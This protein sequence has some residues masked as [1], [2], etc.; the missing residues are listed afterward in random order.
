MS[1]MLRNVPSV[2]ELLESPPLKSLMHRVSQNVVVTRVRQFV[3]D[4]RSQV[5]SA[6]ANV[7]VP[8]V[9]ELAQRI[10]DWIASEERQGLVPVINATGNLLPES[11]GRAPLA[12]EAIAAMAAVAR[13]YAAVDLDLGNGSSRPRAASV[14]KAIL[15]L[16]GG[17]A[18]TVVNHQAAATLI[19]L[20]ALAAGREV[21]VARGQLV[22]DGESY[23]VPD[24]VVASGALLREVGTTN[25]VRASDYAAAIGPQTAAI[26]HVHTTS[27][28]ISGL[29]EQASLADLVAIARRNGVPLL[30]ELGDGSLASVARFGLADVPVAGDVLRT[31][32]DLVLCGGDRWLGGPQCGIIAGR[33]A[34]VD[35]I[36]LHPRFRAVIADKLTLAA[37]A[38]TLKLHADSEVAERSI[39]VLLLL[40]TPLENLQNR[41]ERLAP[42]IAASGVAEVQIVSRQTYVTGVPLPQQALSTVCLALK[43]RAGSV[44]MLA[45]A[46]RTGNPPVLGRIEEGKLLLDLRSVPPRDDALLVSAIEARRLAPATIEVVSQP[47]VGPM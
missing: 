37:L 13:G 42:Q 11:L 15:G 9:G 20:A 19:S 29:C 41:A 27:F 21:V 7:P 26:L 16:A 38:A 22:A 30:A 36:A 2:S 24:L 25:I 45:A 5:Q 33:R 1:N 4:M 35:R 32:A 6:A 17:E 31:G 28:A 23:R 8:A 44:E 39:P 40:A 12:E 34:L 43:P 10:A 47:E 46:L 14:E 3:D 18:A